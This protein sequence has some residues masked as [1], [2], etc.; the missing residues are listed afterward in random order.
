MNKQPERNFISLPYQSVLMIATAYLTLY[1]QASFR[2][3][4]S[5]MGPT[6]VISD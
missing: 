4:H 6:S 3:Y 1:S 5:N 2:V